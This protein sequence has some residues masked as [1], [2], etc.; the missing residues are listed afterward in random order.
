[1]AIL[2]HIRRLQVFVR[3]HIISANQRKRRLVVEVLP[4]AAYPLMCLRQ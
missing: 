3:D 1:V 2:D 4:L